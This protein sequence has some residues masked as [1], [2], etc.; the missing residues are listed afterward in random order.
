M[1]AYSSTFAVSE[2]KSP[3][4]QTTTMLPSHPRKSPVSRPS[5]SCIRRRSLSVHYHY[6]LAVWSPSPIRI[7]S[8]ENTGS[9]LQYVS[10]AAVSPTVSYMLPLAEQPSEAKPTLTSQRLLP[11]PHQPTAMVQYHQQTGILYIK[12]TNSNHHI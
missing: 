9:V 2:P 6:Q 12:R 7:C 8:L 3:T 1:A 11:S 4:S 10:A 5:C